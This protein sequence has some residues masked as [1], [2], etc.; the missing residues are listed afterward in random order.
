ML[1][2]LPSKTNSAMNQTSVYDEV[3][4][5]NE[6]EECDMAL[7]IPYLMEE[8]KAWLMSSRLLKKKSAEDYIKAYER[9]YE[10]L[11]GI[12]GVDL[13]SLLRAFLMTI[14]DETGNDLTKEVAPDL[15]NIYI[16][17]MKEEL[18]R[19]ETAYTNAERRAMMEYHD[20]IV[21]IA[22]S[23]VAKISLEKVGRLPDEDRFLSWLETEYRMD[24]G[25]AKRILSSIKRVNLILPSLVSEPMSFLDVLLALP[26]KDKRAKY[27][28][29]VSKKRNQTYAKAAVAYKTL[30]NG[31]SNIKYYLNFLNSKL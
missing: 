4:N 18:D 17:T 24:Y 23:S 26:D 8:F 30:Q 15:V 31:M 9:A 25:K 19:N 22:K 5:F 1:F 11:Y 27:Y 6:N 7:M 29:L 21:D 28:M 3:L 16:E 13:F 10:S 20:F 2:T 14:P 12:L